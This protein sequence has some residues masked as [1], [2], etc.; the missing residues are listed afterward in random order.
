MCRSNLSGCVKAWPHL[1]TA[2]RADSN[3]A[4]APPPGAVRP[5]GRGHRTH[6][7]KG[8]QHRGKG[9]GAC[10]GTSQLGVANA[11][12]PCGSASEPARPA[13]PAQVTEGPPSAPREQSC[14]SQPEQPGMAARRGKCACLH[15]EAP[16]HPTGRKWG[17]APAPTE[18]QVAC[19]SGHPV[20]PR[21]GAPARSPACLHPGVLLCAS[22]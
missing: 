12:V 18:K 21:L 7:G 11:Q 16:P 15:R 6:G 17:A 1:C 9:Q 13:K 19:V 22:V 4:Q 5:A 10:A 3:Q 20:V 2:L 8:G 14:S